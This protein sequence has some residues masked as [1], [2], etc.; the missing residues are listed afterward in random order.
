MLCYT[1]LT[2]CVILLTHECEA[3]KE[4]GLSEHTEVIKSKKTINWSDPE[5]SEKKGGHYIIRRESTTMGEFYLTK[6]P[7]VFL[8]FRIPAKGNI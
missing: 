5:L 8:L 3:L 7:P 2:E 6:K 4:K 1:T